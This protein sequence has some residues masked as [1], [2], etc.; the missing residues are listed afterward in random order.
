MMKYLLEQRIE[1]EKNWT[2]QIDKYYAPNGFS[3]SI[4]S[5]FDV[6]FNCW[7]HKGYL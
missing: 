5:P 6:A 4:T 2:A 7:I 1:S 3:F